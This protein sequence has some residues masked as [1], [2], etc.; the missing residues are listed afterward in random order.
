MNSDQMNHWLSQISRV[1]LCCLFGFIVAF[2]VVQMGLRW[3]SS[4][5]LGSY[6]VT[7]RGS[8]LTMMGNLSVN[9][10]GDYVLQG[11]DGSSAVFTPDRVATM[12]AFDMRANPVR[13]V[14]RL[15]FAAVIAL[16]MAVLTILFIWSSTSHWIAKPPARK[17][18]PTRSSGSSG[19]SSGSGVQNGQ[20]SKQGPGVVTSL[21]NRAPNQPLANP[22]VASE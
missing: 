5:P 17:A 2:G 1:A 12:S 18:G 20:A 14:G 13:P 15:I 6:I 11:N 21:A 8:N 10:S 16:A 7:L 22:R 3:T 4:D 9:F 19:N